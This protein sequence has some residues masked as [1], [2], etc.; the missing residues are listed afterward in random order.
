[1]TKFRK[2]ILIFGILVLLVGAALGTFIV[3]SLT[4]SLK[5]EAIAL[6]FTVEDAEKSYDGEPLKAEGYAITDGYLIEGHTPVVTFTGEQTDVGYGRSSLEVKILDESGFDVTKEYDIKVNS[7][8]LVVNKCGLRVTLTA[9]D[10][11]YDGTKVDIGDGYAVTSG[12]LAKGHRVNLSIKD[13]WFENSGYTVAGKTLSDSD[14]E[15][16]IVDANGR[17]VTSNYVIDVEGKVNILKRP[18][19][20]SP[21]SASKPYD[22]TPLFC[23]DFKYESGTLASG[24]YIIPSYRNSA[25]GAVATVTEANEDEPLQIV[26]TARVYD[27]LGRDVTEN[28]DIGSNAATLTVR[29]ADLTVLAASKSWPYDGAQHSLSDIHTVESVTGLARGEGVWVQYSD[30]VT[31]VST[32]ANTISLENI[33]ILRDGEAVEEG[34]SNY[35]IIVKDGKLEVTPAPLTVKWNTVEKQYGDSFKGD[36][37]E[38]YTLS[39]EVSTLDVESLTLEFDKETIQSIFDENLGVGVY[40]YQLNTFTV[41]NSTVDITKMFNISVIGGNIKVISRKVTVEAE[42]LEKEYDGNLSFT[43][44]DGVTITNLVEGHRLV[45]VNLTADGGYDAGTPFDAKIKSISVVDGQGNSVGGCYNIENFDATIPVTI[46]KKDITVST[47]SNSKTYDGAPIYRGTVEVVGLIVGDALKTKFDDITDAIEEM[48]NIPETFEILNGSSERVEGFYNLKATDY[49]KIT[50]SQKSVVVSL[51]DN[52]SF[53]YSADWTDITKI[54]SYIRCYDLE[55][56]N[57]KAVLND[58]EGTKIIGAHTVDFD[59]NGAD[60]KLKNNYSIVQGNNVFTLVKANDTVAFTDPERTYDNKATT[61]SDI[62][63]LAGLAGST[64]VSS[65]IDAIIDARSYEISIVCETDFYVYTV[66][67]TY[68]I[69]PA[70]VTVAYGGKKTKTYDGKPFEPN[71]S[72]FVVTSDLNLTVTGHAR[73]NSIIDVKKGEVQTQIFKSFDIAFGDSGEL[74]KSGNIQFNASSVTIAVTITR[75]KLII[76]I[77][78]LPSGTSDFNDLTGAINIFGLMEGDVPDLSGAAYN[79]MII[80]GV[81]YLDPKD[82]K[83]MRGTED[84]T[85]NYDLPTES[86]TGAVG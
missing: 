30:T 34:Q 86:I 22:G 7:G 19:I 14:F 31:V 18:V 61:S 75:A 39:S 5:T 50:I 59:W 21:V 37:S 68:T 47:I 74:V 11:T 25:T 15:P 44:N 1:M 13:E 49:G 16:L 56:D 53:E 9:D 60:L 46:K 8:V 66:T 40:T 43:E 52:C 36:L 67:G 58:A 26:A 4:G 41:S 38:I 84:V 42:G 85:D 69:K 82:I 76:T 33:V 78:P 10:V 32:V 79:M 35:N 51:P 55:A 27:L 70:R 6:E 20:I 81:I 28:Y 57:F 54:Q 23:T 73:A 64:M 17:D 71:D 45:S 12:R 3:L 83:I 29:K 63:A 48:P 77:S 24:H 65:N 80:D 62:L 72:D 2:S